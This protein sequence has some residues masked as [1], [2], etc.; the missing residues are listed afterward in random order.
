MKYTAFSSGW[1]I[2]TK[3]LSAAR[4]PAA[5]GDAEDQ[6]DTQHRR[7]TKAAPPEEGEAAEVFKPTVRAVKETVP[8]K[9]IPKVKPMT[10]LKPR[11]PLG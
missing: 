9:L 5:Q 2:V 4:P 1:P 6:R 11:S 3:G 8:N 7:P 10:P